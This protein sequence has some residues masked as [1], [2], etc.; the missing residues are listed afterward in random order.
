MDSYSHS[1]IFKG[2]ILCKCCINKSTL[3]KKLIINMNTPTN[4]V[5]PTIRT[6]NIVTP[7]IITPNIRTVNINKRMNKRMS[8]N[9]NMT[10][11]SSRN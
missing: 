1:E 4:I 2:K 6:A 10:T 11:K 7:N 8:M 9:M 3:P 5:T